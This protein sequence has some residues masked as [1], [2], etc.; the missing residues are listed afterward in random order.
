M[1][2]FITI[3]CIVGL[4]LGKP[5]SVKTDNIRFGGS[6]CPKGTAQVI[7]SFDSKTISVIF[8]EFSAS[9]ETGTVRD[10]KACN[11]VLPISVPQGSTIG[12]VRVDYRGYAYVANKRGHFA[13]L[14]SDFFWAGNNGYGKKR[15]F[16]RGYDDDFLITERFR[17]RSV[18]YSPCGKNVNFR[19]NTVVEARKKQAN[20]NGLETEIS[21]DSADIRVRG[22]KNPFFVLHFVEKPCKMEKK[23][24]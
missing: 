24:L 17:G 22:K 13:K 16:K 11:V 14:S 21:V 1:I 7:P 12:L 19:M 3:A 4:S 23:S 8:D 9:T 5:F 10:R 18:V 6:G 2:A 15:L 20:S